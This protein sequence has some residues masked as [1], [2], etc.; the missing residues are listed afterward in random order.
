MELTYLSRYLIWSGISS[1][2]L[3]YILCL[4]VVIG[5]AGASALVNHRPAVVTHSVAGI[6]YR[7]YVG[8][9]LD[10]TRLNWC[11]VQPTRIAFQ[12]VQVNGAEEPFIYALPS[13]GLLWP[14]LGDQKLILGL[15][16]AKDLT[17]GVWTISVTQRANCHWYNYVIGPDIS[18][19]TAR[20]MV[21]VVD[22]QVR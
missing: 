6:V 5:A 15:V 20:V 16:R 1:A 21:P 11:D 17:P 8:L 10:R 4:G 18:T 12:D 13:Q 7:G 9:E 14:V 19:I 2:R 3:A 22:G